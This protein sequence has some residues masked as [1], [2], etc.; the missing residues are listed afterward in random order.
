MLLPQRYHQC[1]RPHTWNWPSTKYKNKI[2]PSNDKSCKIILTLMTPCC[3]MRASF[4]DVFIFSI[5]NYSSPPQLITI[6]FQQ[7]LIKEETSTC[8]CLCRNHVD[9]MYT[10]GECMN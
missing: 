10:P 1:T 4:F 7:L 2:T 5:F 3:C 6:N 8:L 9:W